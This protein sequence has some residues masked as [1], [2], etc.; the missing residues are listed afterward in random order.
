MKRNLCALMKVAIY[1]FFLVLAIVVCAS[2]KSVFAKVLLCAACVFGG[3][4]W[5]CLLDCMACENYKSQH[6]NKRAA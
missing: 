6:E 4:L 3:F 2:D 5:D 1:A